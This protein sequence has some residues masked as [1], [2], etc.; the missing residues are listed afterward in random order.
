MFFK[1]KLFSDVILWPIYDIVKVKFDRKNEFSLD[2]RHQIN[3]ICTFYLF[4]RKG[5]FE[6]TKFTAKINKSFMDLKYNRV[7][8]SFNLYQIGR[9]FGTVKLYLSQVP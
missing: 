1:T 5:D 4:N 8:D 3:G 7:E 6:I 2:N 9:Q